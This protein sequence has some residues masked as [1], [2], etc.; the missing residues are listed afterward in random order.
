MDCIRRYPSPLG[1][2]TLARAGEALPGLRLDGQ[3]HFGAALHGA[4]EEKPLPILEE[5]VNWLTLYFSGIDPGFTPKLSV[6]ATP[7]REAVWVTLRTIPFG[8]VVTS[9]EIAARLAG[10]RGAGTVSARAVGGAVGRNPISLI[11]PCHRVVGA[12]GSLTGYAGGI[13]KKRFLLSLEGVRL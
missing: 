13:D 4:P 7:F 9:G 1:G 6:P 2:L 3:K 8:Q 12:N 5:A 10:K 11:I